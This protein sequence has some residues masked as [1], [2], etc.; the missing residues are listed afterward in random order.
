MVGTPLYINNLKHLHFKEINS[1]LP[2]IQNPNTAMPDD[3]FTTSNILTLIRLE[4]Q[5]LSINNSLYKHQLDCFFTKSGFNILSTKSKNLH[6]DLYW[7]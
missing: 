5:Q 3:I 4:K 2:L 7:L 1:A 6:A